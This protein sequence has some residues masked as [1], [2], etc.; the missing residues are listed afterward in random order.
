MGLQRENGSGA[1]GARCFRAIEAEV[2]AYTPQLP[3]FTAF[4]MRF[5]GA[6]SVLAESI[7]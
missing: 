7:G 4:C 5:P 1:A 6:C 3:R 2:Y